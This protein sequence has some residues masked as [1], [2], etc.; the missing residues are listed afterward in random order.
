[1]EELKAEARPPRSVEPV[2]P[3]R[4]VRRRPHQPRIRAAV[5]ADG[6]PPPARRGDQLLGPRH[7]QHGDPRSLRHA[8]AAGAVPAPAARRAGPVVLRDDGAVRR[9]LGRH[10]PAEPDR[11][12]RRPL[13]DQRS[14]VVDER[15]GVAAVQVRDLPRRLRPRRRH[16][17]PAVDD[18]R[19]DGHTG[20]HRRAHAAGLRPRRRRRPLR[21]ALG[22]RAGP[23]RVPARRGGRRVDRAGAPRARPDPPLH[24]RDRH[25]R[26]GAGADVR[27]AQ[28]GSRSAS[29]SPTTPSSSSRSRSRASRSNRRGCSP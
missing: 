24:A 6:P 25:G 28:P 3:R 18:P 4:R 21:D 11:T 14:Q 8:V 7:R 2:P 1:M 13:R 9:Q 10:E 5:R 29:T 22:E 20:R 16:L 17:P 12:R 27:T 26:E 15:G 19:P 23:G